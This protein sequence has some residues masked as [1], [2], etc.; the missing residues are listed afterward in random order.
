MNN[1]TLR[2]IIRESIKHLLLTKNSALNPLTMRASTRNNPLMEGCFKTYDP[3]IVKGF[4]EKRY[5][6]AAQIDLYENENGIKMFRVIVWYTD[7][8]VEIV[9]KDMALCGYFLSTEE[10]H[11]QQVDLRFE[12]SKEDKINNLVKKHKY[13]YHLTPTRKVK[14]ILCQGLYPKTNNKKFNYTGRV[15]CFLDKPSDSTCKYLIYQFNDNNPKPCLNY[16][17]LKIETQKLVNTTFSY[18][19][20]AENCVYTEDVIPRTCLIVDHE[21]KLY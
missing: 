13:I 20:N 7:E 1:K 5:G 11:G 4:L 8:N 16:T 12:P 15:Y 19:P 18:D 9:K 6:D 10:I 21:I 2:G 14:K 17:L 3:E